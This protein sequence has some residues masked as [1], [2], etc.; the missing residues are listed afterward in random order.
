MGFEP[1]RDYSQRIL[2]PLERHVWKKVTYPVLSLKGRNCWPKVESIERATP[3]V[4]NVRIDVPLMHVR[5]TFYT[6]FKSR[7]LLKTLVA[8][9]GIEPPT[10][11][12]SVPLTVI[13]EVVWNQ[14][15]TL[16][17]KDLSELIFRMV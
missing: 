1:T 4:K 5:G 14:R 15:L 8:R 6:I 16:E 3:K 7:K 10:P 12:F 9:D 13:A 17:P 2:S 11:A